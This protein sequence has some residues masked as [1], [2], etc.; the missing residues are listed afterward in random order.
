MGGDYPQAAQEFMTGYQTY[1][2]SNKGPDNLLKLG[3]SLE[4]LNQKD[5]ACTAWSRITK[6]YPDAEAGVVKSANSE[7]QKLK[8]K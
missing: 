5:G 1:P 8:C 7:R 6:D 4:K 3:M 2:K